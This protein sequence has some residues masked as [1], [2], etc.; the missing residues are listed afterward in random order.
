VELDGAA[1]NTRLINDR[2]G[3][4][5]HLRVS[6]F[7]H[8]LIPPFGVGILAQGVGDV[9][10][11]NPVFTEV[12][13]DLRFDLGLV[14]GGGRNF[15]RGLVGGVTAKYI[16]RRGVIKTYTATDIAADSFNPK[17]DLKTRSDFSFDLGVM[18]ALSE[19]T[20]FKEEWQPMAGIVLQ[21][22]TDLDFEEVGV[23]PMQ[24][25][26]G[27]AIHPEIGMMPSTIALDFVDITRRIGTDDD[28]L[29]RTHLG[30]EFKFPKVVSVRLGVNQG[31]LTGGV[32]VNFWIVKFDIATFSEELGASFRQRENR[33]TLAQISVGF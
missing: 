2:I 24:L 21:N 16:Q 9:D 7:P 11:R 13:T 8:L 19:W 5:H 26:L 17:N 30:A 10:T 18:I 4:H 23:Y 25:N 31:Y 3:E 12:T 27:V 29:K 33:R 15:D 1:I 28:F 22:I 20:S 32:T 6:L 14:L